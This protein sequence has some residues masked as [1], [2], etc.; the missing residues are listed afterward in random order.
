[1]IEAS[2][3]IR[4]WPKMTAVICEISYFPAVIRDLKC[5]F[6]IVKAFCGS[7]SD[8]KVSFTAVDA[9]KIRSKHVKVANCFAEFGW[10]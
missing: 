10:P 7:F 5:Q 9:Q 8:S 3:V 2:F 4:D 6:V 1:M